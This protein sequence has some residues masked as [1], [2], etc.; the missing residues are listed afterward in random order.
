MIKFCGEEGFDYG[1]V[2]REWLYFLLYEML[3]LYYGFFQYLRDDI[4]ILQINFDFVVN[5][6]YLFYFYFV[7]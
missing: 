5:L 3:N 2:V 1:G 4:Y 6:E 7:G